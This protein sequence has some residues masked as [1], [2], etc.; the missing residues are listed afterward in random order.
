MGKF[1]YENSHRK[2]PY[3]Y[4]D[5][6]W[7]CGIIFL[8]LFI[9]GILFFNI[10]QIISRKNVID[11]ATGN[12][13]SSI[14]EEVSKFFDNKG[15]PLT[16]DKE[17]ILGALTVAKDKTKELDNKVKESG[18]DTGQSIMSSY[19]QIFQN[20]LDF[21]KKIAT[22]FAYKLEGLMYSRVSN[23]LN[24]ASEKIQALDL[25]DAN[26]KDKI[27]SEIAI[28]KVY[29]EKQYSRYRND[30]IICLIISLLLLI[31]AIYFSSGFGRL[32]TPGFLILM[33]TLPGFFILMSFVKYLRT[34]PL[35]DYTNSDSKIVSILSTSILDAFKSQADSLFTV[36][37]YLFIFALV[38][39][40]LGILG[41]FILKIFQP[42]QTTDI[43]PRLK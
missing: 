9:T 17:V 28:P 30:A 31:T 10:S 39:L 34:S 13:E 22:L 27:M 40:V 35:N 14:K 3:W 8:V 38:L 41:S 29:S 33:A 25:K 37:K 7:V 16:Q 23:S 36:Y 19:F 32:S 1:S 11:T 2:R 21:G 15:K 5:A 26:V 4:V 24:S 6:K 20:P 42:K 18:E 43:S 12:I